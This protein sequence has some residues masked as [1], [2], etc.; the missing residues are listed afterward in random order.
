MATIA[1]LNAANTRT[2]PAHF[3]CV[4]CLIHTMFRAF[5][6]APAIIKTHYTLTQT[7]RNEHTHTVARSEAYSVARSLTHAHMWWLGLVVHSWITK[8]NPPARVRRSFCTSSG[9]KFSMVS[10]EKQFPSTTTKTH[11]HSHQPTDRPS[12]I[13]E[14][15]IR[16]EIDRR[17]KFSN[18]ITHTHTSTYLSIVI[19]GSISWNSLPCTMKCYGLLYYSRTICT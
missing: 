3:Q 9:T 18:K 6:V 14:F 15:L 12:I 19:L 5:T 2:L 8:T 16:F 13:Q 11:T 17:L 7:H 1:D 4:F 10:F